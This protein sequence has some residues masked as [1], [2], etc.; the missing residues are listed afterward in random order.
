[1]PTMDGELV[2]MSRRR[3]D[4]MCAALD[5]LTKRLKRPVFFDTRKG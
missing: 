1:M 3:Y 2:M 4:E 5:S